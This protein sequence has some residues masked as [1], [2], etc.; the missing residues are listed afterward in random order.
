MRDA[1]IAHSR[2]LSKF[3]PAT[4]ALAIHG[5]TAGTVTTLVNQVPRIE[6]PIA[7]EVRQGLSSAPKR[8]PPW[9]FYDARGSELFEQI[10]ELPEYYLTRT[11]RAILSRHAGEMVEAAGTPVTLV[12]LGA[13]TATKTHL[14]VAALLRRQLKVRYFPIDVSESA[15]TQAADELHRAFAGV[16]VKPIVGD[17]TDGIAELLNG[18][19]RKLVLYLGSSIGNFEQSAAVEVLRSVGASLKSGDAMLLGTDLAKSRRVLIPAYDDAAGVTAAFNKNILARI[20]RELGADFDLAK[21][22]HIARW[23]RG[24]SRV[25]MHLASC[26]RQIVKIP[27]LGL[28]VTFAAGETIH[29]ENSYKYT[30]SQVNDLAQQAG[31]KLERTWTDQR[32]WFAVHLLRLA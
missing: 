15:L 32:K 21:F 5:N 27:A 14:I 6:S 23:N 10:T 22:R 2:N 7:E 25:E 24:Q 12:E 9:L 3:L 19:G 8:L 13:G 29:T 17:Y 20:N 16:M 4:S 1:R 18:D 26:I 31:F 28:T 30:L 11:E